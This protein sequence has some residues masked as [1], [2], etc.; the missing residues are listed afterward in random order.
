MDEDPSRTG[1]A[2]VEVRQDGE[3]VGTV[4]LQSG[5]TA[6]VQVPPG[7][8]EAYVDGELVGSGDLGENG[9]ITFSCAA[10]TSSGD[11]TPQP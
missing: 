4:E 10:P 2:L 5:G 9:S 8:V 1:P 3:V 6:G 7:P 11:P